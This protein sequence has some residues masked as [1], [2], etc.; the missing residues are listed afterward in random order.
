M[1]FTIRDVLW[2]TVVVA[3]AV[4]WWLSIPPSSGRVEGTI[5]TVGGKL[6]SQGQ[7]IFYSTD[8]PIVGAK[9]TGGK[10]AVP[11]V[12]P[13]KFVVTVDGSGVSAKYADQRSSALMVEVRDGVNTLDFQLLP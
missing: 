11:N 6:L 7:V 3:L 9:V 4:G 1:R 10:Y 13:G 2:L 5:F 12:P 8:G